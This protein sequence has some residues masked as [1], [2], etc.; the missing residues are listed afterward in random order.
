MKVKEKVL[1]RRFI[2]FLKRKFKDSFIYS[3]P[4]VPAVRMAGIPDLLCLIKGK[5]YAIEFK[6]YPNRPTRLQLKTL[7]DIHRAGGE[8]LVITL[9][10]DG[11]IRIERVY[12]DSLFEYYPAIF[13][14]FCER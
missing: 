7:R 3:P 11:E 10:K 4:N 14:D 1:K 2:E 12:G 9:K 8:A 13:E 5:F 6:V